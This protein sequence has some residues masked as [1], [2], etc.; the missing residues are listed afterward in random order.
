MQERL[1]AIADLPV[2]RYVDASVPVLHPDS[3]VVA[4]VLQV[5]RTRNFVPVVDPATGK[6]AGLISTWDTLKKVREAL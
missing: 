1:R 2:G 3:P 4:A 6:L 5:F